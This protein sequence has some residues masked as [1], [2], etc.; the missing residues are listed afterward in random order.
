[1][2]KRRTV[3]VVL[4]L[5]V[6]IVF[7]IGMKSVRSVRMESTEDGLVITAFSVGKADALL[8]QTDAYVMLIDAGEEDDG[9]YLLEELSA[10]GIE[11][12]D[13]LLITHFDKDHVGGASYLME[14]L[15]VKAVRMP[16]Y[17]GERP[18][19]LAFLKTLLGHPDVERLSEIYQYTVGDL[20]YT[21]YP[22]EDPKKIQDSDKEY[23]N[24]MSL[25]TSLSYQGKRFLLTG[26]IEK[27]RIAQMLESEVDWQHDWIKMPHHGRYQ[28]ALKEL[29][30]AVQPQMAVICCSKKEYAEDKT[31]KLL[32]ENEIEVWDT[33]KGSVI[34]VLKE[35][36]LKV[37]SL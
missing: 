9:P 20:A 5:L 4:L 11:K 13:M 37:N 14:H 31:L 12:V 35:G 34:T 1:M 10:R 27:E 3:E 29:L 26:D 19:Y 23:D 33:S 28:K 25:V 18:E 24:D 30:E 17:Q 22:A 2:K 6:L 36:E 8:L 15:E 21:I 7:W 32:E 16:D